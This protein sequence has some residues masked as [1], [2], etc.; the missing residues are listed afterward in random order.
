MIRANGRG[1]G[2][3]SKARARSGGGPM[4]TRTPLRDSPS[5]VRCRSGIFREIFTEA[6]GN[7]QPPVDDSKEDFGLTIIEEGVVDISNKDKAEVLAA[8]YNNSHPHG[9]GDDDLWILKFLIY[10]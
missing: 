8:L 9:Q 5:P 10:L 2:A 3:R 4:W 7:V 6:F 1:T